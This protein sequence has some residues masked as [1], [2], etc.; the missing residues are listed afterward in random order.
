MA[1][2]SAVATR[3]MGSFAVVAQ[4]LR[5]TFARARLLFVLLVIVAVGSMLAEL[6]P[7]LLLRQIVDT[8]L[9]VDL[10]EGLWRLAAIY[11]A[12]LV[13]SSSL[14]FAQ[15]MITTYLGQNILLDL[16]LLMAEHLAKLPMRYYNT[17]AVGEIMSRL[18][19][20]V[21]VVN[22]LF[23][24]GL[25]NAVANLF[26]AVGVLA[27]MY[28]ISPLL[29]LITLLMVPLVYV[30]SNYFR[31]NMRQ[32]QASVRRSVGSI[33][34]FLQETFSGLRTLKAYGQ[35]E[36]TRDRFQQPLHANLKAVNH[37]AVY[38][39]YLPCVMQV[40]RALTIAIVIYVGVRTN[41]AGVLGLTVGSLAAMADLIGRLF[42][43][44]EALSQE[45]QTLQQALAGLDRIAELLQTP[46]EER[47]ERQNLTHIP[48]GDLKD[49]LVRV[50]GLRFGYAPDK[51]VLRQV[52]LTM[53]H[54]QKV[55]IVG[56]TGAGKT[57]LL[58]LIAGLYRPEQGELTICGY[59]PHRLD[60]TARRRLIG[61]VPQNVHVFEGTVRENITLRDDSISDESVLRAAK[62]VGLHDL[63]MSLP[64]GYDSRLGETNG[65]LS[66][67]Q[68]QL[69]ALARAIVSD[70]ILLLLDEPTSG[71][72]AVTERAVFDAFRAA[73][74]DRTILTI[75]HRLSGVLD[76][77]QVH[78]MAHGEIVQSGAPDELAAEKGWYSVFKQL[79]DLGWGAAT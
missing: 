52:S 12:A 29:C 50:D 73:G 10:A 14:G 47:G 42:S 58:N 65:K 26:K 56:R 69:L 9:K 16:R 37:A 66:Y 55:A 3:R 62:T 8:H 36:Q 79:E 44:I 74:R 75:S 61:V 78:I 27:A 70:P 51:P 67:G 40:L 32:A 19:S 1:K 53:T 77:D 35:E 64:E 22:T 28:V 49:G 59:E 43:P 39:S 46:A 31:K 25:V 13:F 72:D 15:A 54:G 17:N 38:D 60:P 23:S 11:V 24:T 33:N 76:A 41:I 63:I 20:D 71:L 6:M 30:L 7:P 45:V 2:S 57:T 5:T 18:T 4:A 68:T 34:A 48:A 21:E